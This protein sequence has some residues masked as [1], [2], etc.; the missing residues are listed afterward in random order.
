MSPASLESYAPRRA[1]RQHTVAARRGQIGLTSWGPQST[2]PIVLVH[3][4]MDCGAAFQLLVDCLPDEWPL[5]AIDWPG[6]GH[7]DSYEGG[8]WMAEYLADLEWLLDF[9]SPGQAAR[10]IGHSLG[11]TVATIYAGLRP[12]RLRWLVNMEGI[13]LPRVTAQEVPERITS[14]LD[15]M[16]A[17]TP[18]RRY[19][20]FE[21][22]AT[23]LLARNPRL[24]PAN[25]RFLA[26]CWA[27]EI[28][29]GVQLLADVQHQWP[30]PIRYSPEDLYACMAGIRIPVL[31]QVS[32]HSEYLHRMGGAALVAQWRELVSTLQAVTVP[33]TGHLLHQEQPAATAAQIVEFVAGLSQ[34]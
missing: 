11:G 19:G 32:E 12:A 21:E 13:G 14:W 34:H 30:S 27:R 8:Y 17:P 25:A 33:D 15:A 3:G 29:G 31:L 28:S 1:P 6:Y 16:R 9:L 18:A 5:V 22:L 26:R 2:S 7:S 23:V 10:I 24:P 4:W 20:S